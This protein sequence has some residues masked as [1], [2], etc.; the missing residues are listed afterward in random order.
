MVYEGLSRRSPIPASAVLLAAAILTLPSFPG[1][2]V[3]D[4]K[5]VV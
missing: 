1:V 5:S 2:A 4:R 3:G